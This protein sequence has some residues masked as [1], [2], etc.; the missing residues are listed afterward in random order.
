MQK[1]LEEESSLLAEK[2]TRDR[3]LEQK[4]ADVADLVEALSEKEGQVKQ[5]SEESSDLESRLEAITA[6]LKET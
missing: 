2:G 5:L 1:L 6:Q 3:D 4:E